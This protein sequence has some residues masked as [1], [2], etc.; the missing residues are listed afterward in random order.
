MRQRIVR[1]LAP[2][3]GLSLLG[4]GCFGPTKPV[5]GPD[6]GILKS[7]D[8]GVTWANK[9]SLV[10][11]AK[12]VPSVATAKILQVAFDPQDSK[13]IYLATAES[14]LLYS[15]DAGESWQKPSGDILTVG[16]IGAI[17]VDPKD[18][19]VVYAAKGNTI[20]K[21]TTCGRDWERIFFDPRPEVAFTQLIVDWYNPTVLY[22]GTS[23]GDIF[24]SQDSGANW[25]IST[26]TNGTAVVTLA[27]DPRDSRLLYA[28]TYGSGLY[29]TVDG[30]NTWANI[31]KE[32]GEEFADARRAVQLVIDPVAT[33]TVYVVSKYG[34]IRSD[35]GGT[36]WTGLKLTSPP[37][38]VRINS[39]AIDPKNNKRIAYT[40]VGM[41]Q[42]TMDGG[43][44]WKAQKLP[45]TQAGSVIVYDP[46]DSKMLYLGT[47]APPPKQ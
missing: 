15:L 9:K 18:K 29:K 31:R 3:L 41:L 16:R 2:L 5:V 47:T 1:S 38:T 4:A 33:S 42:F 21:T 35:D 39:M 36:T 6:G 43:T 11:G 34:I 10:T 27:I 7:T 40:G 25:Q 26:R 46:Q 44:T 32:F 45:T 20:Y 30:G 8:G 22:S 13:T 17:A 19:C 23:M 37:S 24:R 12:V 14:G 28:A